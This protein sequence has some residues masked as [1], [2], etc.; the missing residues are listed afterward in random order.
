MTLFVKLLNVVKLQ[1]SK[2]NNCRQLLS[3]TKIYH[4]AV[5]LGKSQSQI[6]KESSTKQFKTRILLDILGNHLPRGA[7]SEM[8]TAISFE[9]KR[10]MALL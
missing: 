6:K 9:S 8:E 3:K 10:G 5:L 1:D 7:F 2:S 4:R